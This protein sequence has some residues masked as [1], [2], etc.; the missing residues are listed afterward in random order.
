MDK[1]TGKHQDNGIGT[2]RQETPRAVGATGEA[3]DSGVRR[4]LPKGL[5]FS[6]SQRN[7]QEEMEVV[8]FRAFPRGAGSPFLRMPRRKRYPDTHLSGMQFWL[9]TEHND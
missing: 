4:S 1:S 2:R 7:E 6:I 9:G 8:I 5:P 3:P